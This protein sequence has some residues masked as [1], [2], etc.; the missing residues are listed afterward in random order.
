MKKF[1]KN[2]V[3]EAKKLPKSVWIAAVIIPGGFI[4][5]GT[6]LATVSVVSPKENKSE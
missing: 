5:V 2:A 4:M 6:Y 3:S 1:L